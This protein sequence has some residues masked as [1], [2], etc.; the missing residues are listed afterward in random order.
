MAA[1]DRPMFKMQAPRGMFSTPILGEGGLGSLPEFKDFDNLRISPLRA[2]PQSVS[3]SYAPTRLDDMFG[4]LPSK[5]PSVGGLDNEPLVTLQMPPRP[6]APGPNTIAG[7]LASDA[8]RLR[9]LG[10]ISKVTEEDLQALSPEQRREHEKMFGPLRTEEEER[11]ADK[12]VRDFDTFKKTGVTPGPG[13]A[14]PPLVPAIQREMRREEDRLAR[15]A[16]AEQRAASLTAVDEQKLKWG[17][18]FDINKVPLS[19]PSG[20]DD[21]KTPA[22]TRK[23]KIRDEANFLKELLGVDSRDAAI[24]RALDMAYIGFAIASGASPNA[25]T[26]IAQG[27]L[28]GTERISGRRKEDK[29]LNQK[30]TLAAYQKQVDEDAA[31]AEYAAELDVA[32][33]K[34]AAT[35]EAKALADRVGMAK[36]TSS[37]FVG[38]M[39]AKEAAFLEN[40]DPEEI[41]PDIRK[42]WESE[43]AILAERFNY[44]A[45]DETL[46]QTK[47]VGELTKMVEEYGRLTTVG[48]L[49]AAQKLAADISAAATASGLPDPLLV[50]SSE[51]G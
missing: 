24:E 3:Q 29:D 36:N 28:A 49:E 45:I 23:D 42:A 50:A 12:V 6:A 40:H 37:I 33:A 39:S 7:A 43:S 38:S 32:G 34:A 13:D 44:G 18:E 4:A 11:A 51:G 15:E 26:N 48:D 8:E 22:K 31:A 1:T 19:G 35:A 9:D 27:L 46:S 21:P 16:A 5:E 2:F 41:T 47:A 20:S 14:G 30:L 25:L 10:S 17:M